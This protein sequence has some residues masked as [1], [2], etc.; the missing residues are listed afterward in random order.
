MTWVDIE[1]PSFATLRVAKTSECLVKARELEAVY[2]QLGFEALDVEKIAETVISGKGVLTPRELK[3]LP[4]LIFDPRTEGYNPAFTSQVLKLPKKTRSFWKM[5]FW[6]WKYYYSP[7]TKLGEVVRLTLQLNKNSLSGEHRR[8]AAQIGLF[9]TSLKS[10]V[11]YDEILRNKNKELLYDVGIEDGYARFALGSAVIDILAKETAE[12]A[13]LQALADFMD[14]FVPRDQI[15]P[16]VKSQAMVGMIQT[17]KSLPPNSELVK[18]CAEIAGNTYG[19]PRLNESGWPSLSEFLGGEE[20]RKDCIATVRQWNVFKSINVFFEIIEKT[21]KG[22]GHSHQF[23]KRKAF[24]LAYFQQSAVSDAWVL[25]GKKASA[26]VRQLKARGD[27]D[28]A[29]L[30]YGKLNGATNEQSVLIMKVGNATVVEWSHD[31]AC[32]IWTSSDGRAPALYGRETERQELMKEAAVRITHD[33]RGNWEAKLHAALRD[34]G[35]VR[36]RL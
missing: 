7:G 25:L 4:G 3:S 19:D 29:S 11:L 26:Y 10:Q 27:S 22:E 17:A 2:V 35:K 36:R 13:T 20:V 8:I 1:P 16:S 24:W 12:L 33:H 15:H 6:A 14:I 23:P 32:R 9:D 31:G 30:Q 34:K 18:K 21:T 5:L 28:I